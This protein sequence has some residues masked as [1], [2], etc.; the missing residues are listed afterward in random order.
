MD[1]CIAWEVNHIPR[2]LKIQ[3]TLRTKFSKLNGSN[4]KHVYVQMNYSLNNNENTS[5]KHLYI[6]S[7]NEH[8]KITD[9][10]K[11]KLIPTFLIFMI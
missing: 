9:A 1:S 11:F 2:I 3:V 6:Y 10:N 4:D 7:I 5:K 8:K